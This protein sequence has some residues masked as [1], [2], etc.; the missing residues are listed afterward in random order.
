[1]DR[2]LPALL[3]VDDD[4]PALR[5][6]LRQERDGRGGG[7]ED[8]ADANNAAQAQAQAHAQL[9]RRHVRLS[10]VAQAARL[11]LVGEVWSTGGGDGD[12][13]GSAAAAA[14]AAAE[15][16]RV[17]ERDKILAGLAVNRTLFSFAVDHHMLLNLNVSDQSRLF[18]ALENIPTLRIMAVQ[19]DHYCLSPRRQRRHDSAKLRLPALCSSLPRIVANGLSCLTIT[20]IDLCG[21]KQDREHLVNAVGAV[22]FKLESLFLKGIVNTRVHENMEGFLDP[23][24]RALHSSDDD[25]DGSARPQ[26]QP[27][28]FG[29]GGGGDSWSSHNASNLCLV[30]TRALRMYLTSTAT[31]TSTLPRYLGL[32]HLGLGDDHCQIIATLLRKNDRAPPVE[33]VGKLGEFLPGGA[34][35]GELDL[36]GNCQIGLSGYEAILGL[37]NREH[38]IGKVSVDDVG[39]QAKFGL[40]TEMNTQHGRGAFLQDGVF[41]SKAAWVDW[42]ARL[43]ALENENAN[44]N[45]KVDEARQLSFLMYTLTEKPEFLSR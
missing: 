3:A 15:D 31:F 2:A 6:L 4:N 24:L 7:R 9:R 42:I 33:V 21:N 37:L 26:Q 41:D 10:Q 40:V 5:A 14:A 27:T 23:V 11:L 22:G 13:D 34:V 45:A 12:G 16:L 32:S 38:W 44:A 17:L 19:G 39:W 20:D 1:M 8:C 25:S 29:L 30:S 36:S 35:F 18:R 28:R 43:A